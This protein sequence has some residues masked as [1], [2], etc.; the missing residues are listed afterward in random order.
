M[1]YGAKWQRAKS[2]HVMQKAQKLQKNIIA[3]CTCTFAGSGILQ[4]VGSVV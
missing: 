3:C 2:C 1:A 4:F